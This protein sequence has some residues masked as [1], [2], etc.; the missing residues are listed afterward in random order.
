[1]HR[2]DCSAFQLQEIAVSF[3][4]KVQNNRRELEARSV[5]GIAVEV[6]ANRSPCL[7]EGL[8]EFPERIGI[9]DSAA[10]EGWRGVHDKTLV[11]A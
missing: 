10:V 9:E 4:G 3:R 1:M 5:A 11:P 7:I 8:S 2:T 6:T